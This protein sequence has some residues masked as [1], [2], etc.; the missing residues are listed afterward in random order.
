VKR[1]YLLTTTASTLF[2]RWGF[3]RISREA[4]PDALKATPELT[5]LCPSSAIVMAQDLT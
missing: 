1:L 2:E 3:V 4:L 5:T